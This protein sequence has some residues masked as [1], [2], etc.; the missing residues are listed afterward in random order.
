MKHIE[1]WRAAFAKIVREGGA[2]VR[3]DDLFGA[4]WPPAEPPQINGGS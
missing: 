2:I 1:R 3:W 4:T